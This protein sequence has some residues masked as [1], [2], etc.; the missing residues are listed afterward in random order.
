MK[1]FKN[2]LKEKESLDDKIYRQY[3]DVTN[4]KKPSEKDLVKGLPIPK[5]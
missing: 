2:F 5:V 4:P 3:K 1:T